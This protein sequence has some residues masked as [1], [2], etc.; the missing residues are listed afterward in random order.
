M[1]LK[2]TD[3]QKTTINVKEPTNNFIL[4]NRKV[5]SFLRVVTKALPKKYQQIQSFYLCY[6]Y[7]YYYDKR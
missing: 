1:K 4:K 2:F 7:Y 5:L 3:P 6:Y